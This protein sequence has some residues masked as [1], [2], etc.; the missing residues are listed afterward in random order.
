MAEDRTYSLL[1]RVAIILGVV[2]FG[3]LVYEQFFTRDPGESAYLEGNTYF[4]DRNYAKALEQYDAAIRK[5]PGLIAAYSA[6]GNTL[7]MMGRLDE[8]ILA[9]EE[10]IARAPDFGGY[11]AQRGLIYDLQGKYE[12]AIKD[13]ETSLK[14]D[15]EVAD[16][17]HWLTRLLYN[18]QDTPPTIDKRL[19]YLKE[20]MKLPPG[21]RVLSKPEIDGKARPYEQ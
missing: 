20:Q 1:V 19:I 18:I 7:R 2:V 13:Y 15:P 6:R 17:V 3:F 5:T 14:K 12:K 4:D 9:Y 8:A 11:Y 10:A 21:K 16:G